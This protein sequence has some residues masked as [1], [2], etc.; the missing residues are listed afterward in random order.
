MPAHRFLCACALALAV[1]TGAH[2][3]PAYAVPVAAA[4]ECAPDDEQCNDDEASA[5]KIEDQQK[6]TE[7]DAANAQKQIDAVGKQLDACK[8]GSSECMEKLSGSGAA[9]KQGVADMKD[10]ISGFKT[11]PGNNASSTSSTVCS[12]FAATLPASADPEQSPFPAGQLCSLL[13]S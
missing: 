12:D 4:S 3:S 8:P 9:E 6:K 5:Q 11:E 1:C 7:A 2:M 13:G 10:T